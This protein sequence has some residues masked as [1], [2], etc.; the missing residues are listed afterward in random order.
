METYNTYEATPTNE[1]D[2]GRDAYAS[3]RETPVEESYR[4]T[5]VEVENT[6]RDAPD[7]GYGESP[8]QYEDLYSYQD[9]KDYSYIK[10]SEDHFTAQTPTGRL[11]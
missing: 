8:A 3:Y 5:E 10:T 6:Y 4:H 2:L 9:D 1:Q 11:G 7:N